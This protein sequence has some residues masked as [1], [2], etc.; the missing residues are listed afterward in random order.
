MALHLG[1]MAISG[2]MLGTVPVQKVYLGTYQIWGNEIVVV[3][4]NRSTSLFLKSLFTT[5]DWASNTRKRVVV[6]AGVEIG[7]NTNF[8]IAI[9]ATADGQATSF[10]GEL[11]IDN[12]GTVSGLGGAPNSGGGGDAILANLLG[13]SGQ[14]L[15]V[16]NYGTLRAG[17]GGGGR[18]GNGGAGSYGYNYREPSSGWYSW[19]NGGYEFR[20]TF[21]NATMS[22][23]WNGST[24]GSTPGYASSI[25]AGGWTYLRGPDVD[26]GSASAIFMI[27]R[28]TTAYQPTSG[29]VAGNA[30]RG[31]GFDGAASAGANPVAGGTNAGASG[32]SGDGGA[33]GQPGQTGANGSAGNAG[34]GTA[35]ATGGLAGAYL[36]SSANAIF[37]N[38]GTVQ[39]RL[40]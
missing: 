7:T 16:N 5:A 37:N 32:K 15:I 6:P 31:Q 3:L 29:G 4:G 40:I 28:Q 22:A 19:N 34:S 1:N 12:F 24:V 13:R 17:G 14:K 21:G 23:M 20:Y 27:A 2:L 9:S 11:I 35:G 18:G 8:A 10:G 26:E 39:G 36:A 25:S 38:H 30:G 33:W